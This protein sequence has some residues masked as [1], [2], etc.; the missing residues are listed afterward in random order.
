MTSTA[1]LPQITPTINGE[2]SKLLL[3]VCGEG[4]GGPKRRARVRMEVAV[5]H[6]RNAP[7]EIRYI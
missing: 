2:T 1:A 3:H 4:G 5:L 7:I 6:E